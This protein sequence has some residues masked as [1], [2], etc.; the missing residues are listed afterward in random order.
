MFQL[1]APVPSSARL[2]LCQLFTLLALDDLLELTPSVVGLGCER[3]GGHG[4][5]QDLGQ[6]VGPEPAHQR[7]AAGRVVGLLVVEEKAIDLQEGERA[8]EKPELEAFRGQPERQTAAPL[9]ARRPKPPAG[10]FYLNKERKGKGKP[11]ELLPWKISAGPVR[12][13]RL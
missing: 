7:R 2:P 3:R 10:S 8:G 11:A 13:R 1:V 5:P 6:H 4:Q 9:L 12:A